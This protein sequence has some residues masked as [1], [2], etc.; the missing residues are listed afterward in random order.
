MRRIL[1]LFVILTLNATAPVVAQKRKETT[2]K[3]EATVYICDSKTAYAYHTS[4]SCRG[5]NR[6]THTIVKMTKSE[7]IRNRRTPCKV[8]P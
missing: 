7:A 3:K 4:A 1:L 2:Y 8:C 5:L 6:C